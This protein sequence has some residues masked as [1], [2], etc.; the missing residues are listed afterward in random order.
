MHTSAFAKVNCASDEKQILNKP[1]WTFQQDPKRES[2]EITI[3]RKATHARRFW[4]WPPYIGSRCL[5]IVAYHTVTL[6]TDRLCPEGPERL[7][8]KASTEASQFSRI[9]VRNH[10]VERATTVDQRVT[11]VGEAVAPPNTDSE[12]KGT[13]HS[14]HCVASEKSLSLDQSSPLSSG[15]VQRILQRFNKDLSARKDD[16]RISRAGTLTGRCL[17]LAWNS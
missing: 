10:R 12:S 14:L 1:T 9:S 17:S 4:R 2:A 5:S 16:R 3:P 15:G 6:S 7:N 13:S 8:F 11:V